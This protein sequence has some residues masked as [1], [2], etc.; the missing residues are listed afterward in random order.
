MRTMNQQ[1]NDPNAVPCMVLTFTHEEIAL[2][3]EVLQESG[4]E[5]DLKAWVLD[6]MMVD[7]DEEEPSKYEGSADRVIN[8]VREFVQD[9]PDTI[10]A[11]GSIVSSLLRRTLKKGPQ[12]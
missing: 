5:D 7:P 9:N 12:Q 8:N 3:N 4:Y 2:V 11:A 10:R 1:A 6:H